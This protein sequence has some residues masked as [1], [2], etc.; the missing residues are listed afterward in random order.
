MDA[1]AELC[2]GFGNK[3]GNYDL[4]ES[5][6]NG[7]RRRHVSGLGMT[8]TTLPSCWWPWGAGH[9]AVQ[10]V[11]IWLRMRVNQLLLFLLLCYF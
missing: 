9:V 10:A 4:V 11:R 1:R 8:K 2:T 7:W 6:P 5:A 3:E